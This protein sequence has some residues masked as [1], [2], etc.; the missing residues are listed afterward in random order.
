[1]E[2]TRINDAGVLFSSKPVC[3]LQLEV[4]LEGT[5][6]WPLVIASKATVYHGE[7]GIPPDS[8]S[9]R[10]RDNTLVPSCSCLSTVAS[11]AHR[12][13]GSPSSQSQSRRQLADVTDPTRGEAFESQGN[14]A[15]PTTQPR[16]LPN[17]V[18]FPPDGD[19]P[20]GLRKLLALAF[21]KLN[22]G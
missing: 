9:D 20:F 2:N 22:Q 14:P 19:T 6:P 17:P 16:F 13:I 3:I 11:G 18:P 7:A 15:T 12:E 1:M 4:Q 10:G 21:P 5:C 8:S